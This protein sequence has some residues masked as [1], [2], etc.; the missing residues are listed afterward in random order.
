MCQKAKKKPCVFSWRVACR[1]QRFVLFFVERGGVGAIGP[2]GNR[3]VEA[4]FQAAGAVFIAVAGRV[5]DEL[6][7]GYARKQGNGQRPTPSPSPPLKKL[8]LLHN[9]G[10]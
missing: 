3:R 7:R 5:G 9:L 6:G 10:T 1:R 2:V 4:F 8:R